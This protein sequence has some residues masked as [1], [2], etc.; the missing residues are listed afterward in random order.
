[1][2]SSAYDLLHQAVLHMLCEPYVRKVGGYRLVTMK[3]IIDLYTDL[4][5]N[6]VQLLQ[7]GLDFMKQ[8]EARMSTSAELDVSHRMAEVLRQL[9]SSEEM[10]VM[11]GTP[12]HAISFRLIP[13]KRQIWV[14]NSGD[15]LNQHHKRY[16]VK[17]SEKVYYKLI[18]VYQYDSD[19]IY[20][21]QKLHVLKSVITCLWYRLLKR[22]AVFDVTTFY[23]VVVDRLKRDSVPEPL[24]QLPDMRGVHELNNTLNMDT[25]GTNRLFDTGRWLV[26]QNE[27]Y[28]LP[29]L[30][31]TC[32]YQSVL[33]LYFQHHPMRAMEQ[34]IK[35]RHALWGKI[36]WKW[37]KEETE[38]Q[39]IHRA[40]IRLFPKT[41]AQELFTRQWLHTF[42]ATEASSFKPQDSKPSIE[43]ELMENVPSVGVVFVRTM[44]SIRSTK[45]SLTYKVL[46]DAIVCLKMIYKMMDKMRWQTHRLGLKMAKVLSSALVDMP[47]S[48][49]DVDVRSVAS[50]ADV[51]MRVTYITCRAEYRHARAGP[52]LGRLDDSYHSVLELSVWVFCM[53][54][55]L[56]QSSLEKL[57]L[58]HVA[59]QHL[60][61]EQKK[62]AAWCRDLSMFDTWSQ[63]VKEYGGWLPDTNR[64]DDVYANIVPDRHNDPELS[65]T[66][67][68][69]EDFRARRFANFVDTS[70]AGY[71]IVAAICCPLMRRGDFNLN[72]CDGAGVLRLALFTRANTMGIYNG[73]CLVYRQKTPTTESE[74]Q[75]AS[76]IEQHMNLINKLVSGTALDMLVLNDDELTWPSIPITAWPFM[77]TIISDHVH[78]K[79]IRTAMDARGILNVAARMWEVFTSKEVT[80]QIP[81][82][83]NWL[84]LVWLS[85]SAIAAASMTTYLHQGSRLIGALTDRLKSGRDNVSRQLVLQCVIVLLTRLCD[86]SSNATV[87]KECAALAINMSYKPCMLLPCGSPKIKRPHGNQLAAEHSIIY[88]AVVQCV[89]HVPILI[90]WF[91]GKLSIVSD[92]KVVPRD[93]QRLRIHNDRSWTYHQVTVQPGHRQTLSTL[94]DGKVVGTYD[95]KIGL[96]RTSDNAIL[97]TGKHGTTCRI[98]AKYDVWSHTD[99]SKTIEW[100]CGGVHWRRN[101]PAA[102]WC[103]TAVT[104]FQP[105]DMRTR[106]FRLLTNDETPLFVR[107]WLHGWGTTTTVF[108]VRDSHDRVGLVFFVPAG[109]TVPLLGNTVFN[110]FNDYRRTWTNLRNVATAAYFHSSGTRLEGLSNRD[111]FTLCVMAHASGHERA[112][113]SLLGQAFI[114]G[115]TQQD[116]KV[117]CHNPAC[118]SGIPLVFDDYKYA[119]HTDP[120]YASLKLTG[121]PT[122]H[123]FKWSE[124]LQSSPDPNSLDFK[125]TLKQFVPHPWVRDYKELAID[126]KT[127]HERCDEAE[128]Q[129]AHHP[130]SLFSPLRHSAVR[131]NAYMRARRALVDHSD[132]PY[133]LRRHVRRFHE[134]AV[135]LDSLEAA[136]ETGTGILLSRKQ[137]RA[138]R[139]MAKD[140]DGPGR[141]HQAVMGLGKSSVLMPL[142][143]LHAL[144]QGSR[145]LV[146]QPEHL[147]QA[148]H[149]NIFKT[150]STFNHPIGRNWNWIGTNRDKLGSHVVT[151]VS[152][153]DLK[154]TALE[155]RCNSTFEHL[156]PA[157]KKVVVLYDEIDSM[158]EPLKSTLN[159]PFETS[160]HPI[161]SE[162][163]MNDYYSVIVRLAES[164]SIGN[165]KNGWPTGLLDKLRRD[166][167]QVT[168]M[169]LHVEYGSIG[170][171][172]LA[173]PYVASHV[174]DK[175]STFADVDI[176]A[177]LTARML[178][179]TGLRPQDV[180]EFRR[181]IKSFPPE[182]HEPLM[183][184]AVGEKGATSMLSGSVTNAHTS[185]KK[186]V[187]WYL[188]HVLLP[189]ILRVYKSRRNFSFMDLIG[190][191]CGHNK[192]GFSGTTNIRM[193]SGL[194]AQNETMAADPVRSQFA[195]D[196]IRAAL[197]GKDVRS[198][199]KAE[200]VLK[201][202]A[203]HCQAL[204]DA[205]AVLNKCSV[206][207]VVRRLLNANTQLKVFFINADDTLTSRG[208][209]VRP[210]YYFDH[211][212]SRGTDMVLPVRTHGLVLVDLQT[213]TYTDVAQ[214]AFRL[215]ELHYGQT[216]SFAAVKVT[217]F[218]GN[219]VDHL[220]N[221]ERKSKQTSNL[222]YHIQHYKAVRRYVTNF[223]YAAYSETAPYPLIESNLIHE[224]LVDQ[225]QPG[226]WEKAKD[227]E[228]RIHQIGSVEQQQQ[229]QQ[230][231]NTDTE[232]RRY[233]MTA[234]VS[235]MEDVLV[236]KRTV[237]DEHTKVLKKLNWSLSPGLLIS[238]HPD[239]CYVAVHP[240]GALLALSGS[241]VHGPLGR[242]LVGLFTT[243]GNSVGTL[244]R[245]LTDK[246]TGRLSLL[247]AMLQGVLLL[248]EQCRALW[249]L[250]SMDE[251]DLG[252]L[253]KLFECFSSSRPAWLVAMFM[254]DKRTTV[255]GM[256]QKLKTMNPKEF[257]ALMTRLKNPSPELITVLSV[258]QPIVI[259]TLSR[260]DNQASSD[261]R[262]P[263]YV[264]TSNGRHYH[265]SR[266]GLTTRIPND[267]M[268][269][270]IDRD[271]VVHINSH[272]S[273]KWKTRT[274]NGQMRYYIR[275]RG[276]VARVTQVIYDTSDAFDFGSRPPN[277]V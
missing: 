219:L 36:N 135:D 35:S 178:L 48:A 205:G 194:G 112:F 69:K 143:V 133:E 109:T 77:S 37:T 79:H 146:V 162:K 234:K 15:G 180:Q 92:S 197:E 19:V 45:G 154:R 261:L 46:Q 140:L 260:S 141:V 111:A 214:A 97:Q 63:F 187:R 175:Q 171:K 93:L 199:Q 198:F 224:T 270:L 253:R 206:D 43:L 182:A 225:A 254:E 98:H 31:G 215:R 106:R 271:D 237:L 6:F 1:M 85:M 57:P 202:A 87:T 217:G 255:A 256:I 88:E 188:R 136:F 76:S 49:A 204:I 144:E 71:A 218:D 238:A 267:V 17:D 145:V 192:I 245:P 121:R 252:S 120:G 26:H 152:D 127:W 229:Q 131:L 249:S 147:L 2:A 23:A 190:N 158:L 250:H 84:S 262:L 99:G 151:L 113:W 129:D 78:S 230:Q 34:E 47:F 164:K 30:A 163:K 148:A 103:D 25:L 53:H 268:K 139:T 101:M 240:D 125:S 184:V 13:D 9:P 86:T 70:Y 273:L 59:L 7:R 114:Y 251:A 157:G 20:H 276:N 170:T 277:I 137:Q 74:R 200:H 16:Q 80:D 223:T 181:H 10:I 52:L 130:W 50:A 149:K 22:P 222:H 183:R 208:K 195:E 248:P 228:N 94:V 231:Q 33:W 3:F 165:L 105:R 209:G 67:V 27:V 212:H 203:E 124:Y 142:L 119:E 68:D 196:S 176:S 266:H 275:S 8:C 226:L 159:I 72:W 239:M 243:N 264:W 211:Q 18:Q 173:V 81:V 65:K 213:S 169:K 232:P 201:W 186:L 126:A 134:A 241:E 58:G 167:D 138:V 38:K 274:S 236:Y 221:I 258:Q 128:T 115:D 153:R 89:T 61:F 14:C 160:K 40:I 118:A 29:Q 179:S 51:L 55:S 246:E 207:D 117:I 73:R 107:P 60:L 177:L 150:L 235:T 110:Q 108:A 210:F 269:S 62:T 24:V 166:S 64:V 244:V 41:N 100:V 91:S 4:D 220:Q 185:S 104:S 227:A 168:K 122:Q 28:A 123:I 32:T 75:D 216:V 259:N 263:S 247:R 172:M 82:V 242:D 11:G 42:S 56:Q 174:P 96:Q 265:K 95:P 44:R 161:V 90:E 191:G 233:C 66:Y 54:D 189:N 272:K 102:L 155:A 12:K 5:G 132:D 83:E 156:L 257:V 116:M 193:P 39:S 21:A